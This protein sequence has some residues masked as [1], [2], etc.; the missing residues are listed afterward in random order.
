MTAPTLTLAQVREMSPSWSAVFSVA[1]VLNAGATTPYTPSE[2]AARGVLNY[3]I[4][5]AFLRPAVLGAAFGEVVCRI[6]EAALPAFEEAYPDDTRPRD[7]IDAARRCFA[8]PTPANGVRADQAADRAL[9]ASAVAGEADAEARAARA[10]KWAAWAAARARA[11]EDAEAAEAAEMA[12][13]AAIAAGC[14]PA[15]VIRIIEGAGQ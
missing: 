9:W 3:S 14:P 13:W 7:A 1:H 11:A 2:M 12:A 8:N 6:A 4:I 10:A 5:R 15:T